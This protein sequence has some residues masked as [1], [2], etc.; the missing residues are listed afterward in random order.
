[1]IISKMKAWFLSCW[2]EK[3]TSAVNVQL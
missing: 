2:H 3:P 1:M